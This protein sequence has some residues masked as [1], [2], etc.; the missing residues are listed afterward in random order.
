MV[1]CHARPLG[2]FINSARGQVTLYMMASRYSRLVRG[3]AATSGSRWCRVGRSRQPAGRRSQQPVAGRAEQSDGEP[4][5]AAG[6]S[7]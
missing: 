5:G 3:M 1:G 6:Q 7:N 4:A 2:H